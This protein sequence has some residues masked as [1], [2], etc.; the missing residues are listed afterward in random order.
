MP[1]IKEVIGTNLLLFT[2]FEPKF[3]VGDI[4]KLKSGSPLMTVVACDEREVQVHW[5]VD[6][7]LNGA[8]HPINAVRKETRNGQSVQRAS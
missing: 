4:V 8:V 7:Q 6:N 2:K 3:K 5:Y 1:V